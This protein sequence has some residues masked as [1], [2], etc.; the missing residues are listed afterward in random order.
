MSNIMKCHTKLTSISSLLQSPLIG[1]SATHDDPVEYSQYRESLN[2]WS[3]LSVA[4]MRCV[5]YQNTN[6]L[7]QCMIAL[8]TN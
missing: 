6:I 7:K 8:L 3:L 5:P 2:N 1:L 4:Y